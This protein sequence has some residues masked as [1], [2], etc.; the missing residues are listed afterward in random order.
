MAK[1]RRRKP[2][3][4]AEERAAYERDFAERTVQLEEYLARRVRLTAEL[5]ERQRRDAERR[6][7]DLI[8]RLF[9]R[10]AA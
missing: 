2:R 4:S 7:R 10:P 9:R 8:G 1:R 6:R 5:K 3:V